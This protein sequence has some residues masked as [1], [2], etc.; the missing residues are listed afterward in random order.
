MVTKEA[1]FDEESP[2]KEEAS[3]TKTETET[4][5][6]PKNEREEFCSALC[7]KQRDDPKYKPVPET[8]EDGKHFHDI[9]YEWTQNPEKSPYGPLIECWDVSKVTSMREMFDSAANFNGDLEKWDVS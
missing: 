6:A 4:E 1:A 8:L 3:A 9:V 5:T 7:K 2:E